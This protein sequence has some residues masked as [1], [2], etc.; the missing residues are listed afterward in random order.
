MTL[1]ELFDLGEKVESRV[2]QYW[3]YWSVAI[4]ATGGWLF[5][6]SADQMDKMS[7][8]LVVLGLSVFFFANLSV[9]YVA[10]RFAMS[11]R[12]E[13]SVIEAKIGA[14][15][16]AALRKVVHKQDMPFRLGLTF[17]MHICV[18]LVV[19]AIVLSKGFGLVECAATP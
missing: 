1:V 6:E 19:V 2:N 15:Q 3:T 18:D 9:L 14:I 10:T 13:I 7:A 16:S 17:A 11:V 5:S 12:E 4:F 8:V